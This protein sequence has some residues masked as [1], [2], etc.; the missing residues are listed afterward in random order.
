MNVQDQSSSQTEL[1]SILEILYEIRQKSRDGDYIY[2]GE[3]EC[4]GKVS[5]TLY[6]KLEA[7][8]VLH[9]DVEE[10]QKA[11]LRAA[12]DYTDETDDFKIL[13]QLQHFGGKTNLIDF[14]TDYLIALF[15][16]ANGSPGEDGRFILLNKTGEVRGWI[17]EVRDPDP[18]SRPW[19]QKSIFVRPPDGFIQPDES[20]VIPKFLKRPLLDYL[21]REFDI[22]HRRVYYDLHGFISSRDVRWNVYEEFGKGLACQVSGEEADD[23]EEKDKYYQVAVEHCSN[24]IQLMPEFTEAYNGR[25][26]AYLSKSDF[27]KAINDFSKAIE[28][29]PR[30]AQAY[31]GRSAVYRALEEYDKAIV[32]SREAIRLDPDN[33]IVYHTLGLA[34]FFNNDFN[35]AISSLN[36]AIRLNSDYATAYLHRGL[37]YREKGDFE[38]TI[39]DL[40]EAIKLDTANDLAYYIRG[41]AWL[42]LK[43]WNKAKEDLIDA[44]NKGLNVITQFH[45][46]Y[47]SIAD[48]EQEIGSELPED[49]AVMLRGQ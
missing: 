25:G 3:P 39:A 14:T 31:N 42:H 4:Y 33:A 47:K 22:S 21:E 30:S 2:R 8:Q 44:V 28:L 23:T 41:D 49:I 16:A 9:L 12:K 32:D 29:N 15:F 17:R 11:E 26:L 37:A 13:V 20:I 19:T 46:V 5:S 24:A 36:E 6:R 35:N 48:F 45:N 34:Y 18:K 7:A 10:V 43:K 1:N 38:K 27:D 40:D